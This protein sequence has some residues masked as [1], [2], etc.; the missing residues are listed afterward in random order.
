M[1]NG[2]SAVARASTGPWSGPRAQ[3]SPQTIRS[4][5]IAKYDNVD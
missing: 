4:L 3:T 2:V 5:K 1:R